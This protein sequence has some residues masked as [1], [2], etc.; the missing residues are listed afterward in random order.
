MCN[1]TKKKSK[2]RHYEVVIGGN[3]RTRKPQRSRSAAI[4]R[5]KKMREETPKVR[6]LTVHKFTPS[7][8]GLK[9]EKV[10]SE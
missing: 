4:T 9:E 5:A 6:R 10:W 8:K 1:L 3:V 2:K 7:G